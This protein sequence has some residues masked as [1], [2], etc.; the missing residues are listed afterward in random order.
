[1][2]V[3]QINKNSDFNLALLNE[4][5]EKTD[6]NIN[7]HNILKDVI[8]DYSFKVEYDVPGQLIY[9]T[10]TDAMLIC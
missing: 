9:R 6:S 1:M 10:L 5:A 4:L 2:A 3:D 8:D 7:S